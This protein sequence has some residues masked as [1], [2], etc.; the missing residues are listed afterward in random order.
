MKIIFGILLAILFISLLHQVDAAKT[1]P[2]QVAGLSATAASST[3]IDLSVP[4][5]VAVQQLL[6]TR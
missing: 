5:L 1:A 4:H 2:S 6:D 3:Q